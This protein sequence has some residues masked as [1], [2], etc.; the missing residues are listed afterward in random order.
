MKIQLRQASGASALRW[1]CW[2]CFALADQVVAKGGIKLKRVWRKS[3]TSPCL[4]A[5]PSVAS[6]MAHGSQWLL[7]S[8]LVSVPVHPVFFIFPSRVKVAAVA[9]SPPCW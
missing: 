9:T 4:S 3:L 5:E 1:I 2:N 7:L 8:D 6:A